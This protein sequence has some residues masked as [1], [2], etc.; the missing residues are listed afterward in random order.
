MTKRL[1][2]DLARHW[3][4]LRGHGCMVC[5]NAVDTVLHHARGGS[6]ADFGY[7]VGGAQK[8]SDWLVMPLCPHHHTGDQGIHKIGV[9]TWE[10]RY[11]RQITHLDRIEAMT[12]CNIWEKAKQ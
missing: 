10:D 4:H 3:D 2:S 8:A 1:P 6:M 7:N 12:G 5:R 9:Q 11:G